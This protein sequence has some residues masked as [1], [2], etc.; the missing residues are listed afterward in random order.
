[1]TIYQAKSLSDL[2]GIAANLL[3]NFGSQR[4]VAFYGEMGVGKTT[5]I[6]E[7]CL[8]L[9]IHEIASSPTFSIVN[10]YLSLKGENIYHFDFYRIEKEEEVFD[11]GYEDYFYSGDYCFIEWPE[12]ISNLLPGSTT[13]VEITLDK[14]NNRL[15]A[16]V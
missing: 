1:L 13:K 9:G 7:L 10:E 2:K 12:K 8:Q 3:Q 5:L 6:K 15:I 16:V 11:L 4:V 14:E